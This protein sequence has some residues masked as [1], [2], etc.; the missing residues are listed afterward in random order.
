MNKI[1]LALLPGTL[2]TSLLWERQVQALGDIADAQVIDIA[3]HDDL[4]ALA[5]HVIEV[6]PQPFAVAGLSYGGII[7]F[8]IWRQN[9]AAVSHMA[10][11]NT[12]PMPASPQKRAAQEALVQMARSGHFKE[13]TTEHLKDTMLHPDHRGDMTLRSQVL[14]MAQETG[15]QGFVNQIE[16]QLTRPDSRPA[17]PAIHCPTLV[18]TGDQDTL[19]TPDIHRDMASAMPQATLH[20]IENCGHLST[21]E[22][23]EGVS[24][25]MR[26]WL[27]T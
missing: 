15:V 20:I 3:Q 23:P 9:A 17:L 24:R 4:S 10:L 26:V 12:T 11:M 18:L 2:C 5:L 8:E 22:Q 21:M 13:V 14:A 16:A 27:T 1:P 7:A 6:M 19:C 25:L